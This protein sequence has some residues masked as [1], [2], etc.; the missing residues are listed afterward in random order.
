[1]A[2]PTPKELALAG[3]LLEL[4]SQEFSNHGCN[5]LSKEV[6]GDLTKEERQS[7]IMEYYLTNGEPEEA[8][9]NRDDIEDWVL[10]LHLANQLKAFQP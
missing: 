9:E 2:H 4:A 6:W 1:M 7:I 5:D 8:D 3:R 10:M